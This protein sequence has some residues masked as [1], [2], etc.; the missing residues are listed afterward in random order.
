MAGSDKRV[1]VT[2]QFVLSDEKGMMAKITQELIDLPYIGAV[3]LEGK[4]LEMLTALHEIAKQKAAGETT[5]SGV[6]F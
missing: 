5:N 2:I 3:F 4:L 1:N 6:K